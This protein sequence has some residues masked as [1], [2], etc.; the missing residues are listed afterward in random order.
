MCGLH[1]R[2]PAGSKKWA[3]S[4]AA[5]ACLCKS[6]TRH[7]RPTLAAQ[8]SP[9][10]PRRPTPRSPPTPGTCGNDCNALIEGSGFVWPMCCGQGCRDA[11]SDPAHC[12]A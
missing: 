10:D 11:D 6:P 4:S 2:V 1:S 7:R 5:F 9:P 12:G 8:P 3:R